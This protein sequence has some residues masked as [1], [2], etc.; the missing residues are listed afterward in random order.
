M[1]FLHGSVIIDL[2]ILDE[3]RKFNFIDLFDFS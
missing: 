2:N 1:L 3:I